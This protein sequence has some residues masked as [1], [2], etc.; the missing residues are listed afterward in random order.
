MFCEIESF[1]LKIYKWPYIDEYE[2]IKLKTTWTYVLIWLFIMV[3]YE[4]LYMILSSKITSFEKLHEKQNVFCWVKKAKVPF[5]WR[6]DVICMVIC[7]YGEY[8]LL[9]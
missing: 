7:I 5:S 6:L 1:I 3:L 9:F 2:D 4:Y 8:V